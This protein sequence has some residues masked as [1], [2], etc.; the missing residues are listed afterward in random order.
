MTSTEQSR[1]P[2]NLHKRTDAPWGRA[3][4]LAWYHE[5]VAPGHPMGHDARRERARRDDLGRTRGSGGP[6]QP[7]CA[8]DAARPPHDS[9][10]SRADRTPERTACVR[11]N[12]PR[13]PEITRGPATRPAPER[14]GEAAAQTRASRSEPALPR[15]WTR[16]KCLPEGKPPTQAPPEGYPAERVSVLP[17][18]NRTKPGR[19]GPIECG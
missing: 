16:R 15:H 1:D 14:V 13:D 18:P 19:S 10:G 11:G 3:E 8:G 5:P 12:H 9:Q 17:V 4:A 6:R 2:R 7:A